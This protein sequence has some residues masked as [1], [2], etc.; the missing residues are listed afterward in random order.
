MA[1]IDQNKNLTLYYGAGSYYKV[2]VLNDYGNIAKNVQVKFTLNGK[3][4][5]KKTNSKGIASL[6]ITLKPKTYTISATYKGFTVKNKVKVKPTIVTKNLSKKKAKIVKFTAK[7]INS[8]GA[9]LKYKYITFKFKSKKY[10]RKTNKYG[11][12]TLS[13]K[14]LRKGKYVIYSTYGKL[15][16]K[17]TIR[18]K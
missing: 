9:I 5:Y 17:N 15:T 3:N 2:R 8:K 13:L 14:N 16:V 4:Y 11:I 7:L 12:A 1:R 10:K 6:K 18:I